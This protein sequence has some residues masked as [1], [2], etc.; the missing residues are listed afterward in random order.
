MGSL[1]PRD[2]QPKIPYRVRVLG[3]L[4]PVAPVYAHDLD[5]A[6]KAAA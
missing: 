1:L 4:W 2:T 6:R 5:A 3:S